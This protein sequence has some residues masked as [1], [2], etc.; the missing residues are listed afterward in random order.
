MGIIKNPG[1]TGQVLGSFPLAMSVLFPDHFV[2]HR[3]HPIGGTI[4]IRM[5]IVSK[6]MMQGGVV[7]DFI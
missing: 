3:S 1:S 5:S 6:G 7:A 4:V 2:F